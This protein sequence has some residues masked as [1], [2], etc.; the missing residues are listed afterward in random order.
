[1]SG[2]AVV[3]HGRVRL[4]VWK[5][6]DGQTSVSWVVD[7]GFVGHDLN[8]GSST[9]TKR[10]GTG[11]DELA[12]DEAVREMRHT[13]GVDGPQ[14][15]SSGEVV[16][17]GPSSGGE[18]DDSSVPHPPASATTVCRRCAPD[19]PY[20]VT[21]LR[22][23]SAVVAAASWLSASVLIDATSMEVDSGT[24]RDLAPLQCPGRRHARRCRRTA[25]RHRSAGAV[26]D[27]RQG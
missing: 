2:D 23:L 15:T 3:V 13:M 12:N 18:A 9:F 16:E 1:M 24:A 7:A 6:E 26:A 19:L 27:R 5:R 20:T 25:C 21:E 8:R 10:I 17:P 4:D 11:A 14:L 22:P